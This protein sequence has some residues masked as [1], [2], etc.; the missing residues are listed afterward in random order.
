MKT[1]AW[2]V[3]DAQVPLLTYDYSFGPG[4]ANALAVGVDGGLF[5]LSPPCRV[6]DAVMD[7]LAAF[8]PVKALVATNAFHH[9]GIPAWKR[10][11]PDAAIYAPA[12]SVARVERQSGMSGIQPLAAA[13][14]GARLKLVDLPHYKTGEVLAQIESGR[15]RVWYI[16]DFVFNMRVLP[17]NPIA[18]FVFRVSGSAPGLKFNNVAPLF[19][20]KDKAALKHWLAAEVDRAPPA[21]LI[22]AHGDV[23]EVGADVAKVRKLFAPR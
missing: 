22:P 17:A 1:K 6:D 4:R 15:G 9:M 8:G 3:F 7:A 2:K 13:A 10:R 16:T 20:V 21:W 18:S 14:S 11:F 23:V 12:Q 19:M 5:V